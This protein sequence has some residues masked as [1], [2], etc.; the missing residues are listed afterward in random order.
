LTNAGYGSRAWAATRNRHGAGF[1][2]R[3]LGIAGDKL[4][5]WARTFGS[6]DLYFGD[7]GLIYSA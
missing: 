7:D 4:T 2:D 6:S 5:Q 3:G 1:W